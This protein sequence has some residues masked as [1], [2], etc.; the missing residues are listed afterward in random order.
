MSD[1]ERSRAML[2]NVDARTRLAGSNR[3][4]LL[5]FSLGTDEIFGITVFNLLSTVG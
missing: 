2:L 5:L 3:M 4:E 1:L